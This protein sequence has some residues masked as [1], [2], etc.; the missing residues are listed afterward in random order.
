MEQ[1]RFNIDYADL[2]KKTLIE[3]QDRASVIHDERL[4][5]LSQVALDYTLY[6]EDTTKYQYA[7]MIEGEPTNE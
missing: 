1:E 4:K 2:L 3:I 7:N 5:Y 6:L